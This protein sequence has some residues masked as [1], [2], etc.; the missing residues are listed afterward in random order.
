M[1]RGPSPRLGIQACLESPLL[2]LLLFIQA[3]VLGVRVGDL[4][5]GAPLNCTTEGSVAPPFP[6]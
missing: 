3:E 4:R 5:A 1:A 2:L 6:F